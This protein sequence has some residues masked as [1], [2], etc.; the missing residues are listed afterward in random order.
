MSKVIFN[1]SYEI[2]PSKR[3][4]FIE[5]MKEYKSLIAGDGIQSYGLYEEK[6]KPNHFQELF[7]FASEES[8]DNFDDADND[9]LN[10]LVSKLEGMKVNKTTKLRTLHEVSLD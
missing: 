6:G 3:K 2:D 9:R 7:V 1:V 10:I 5:S 4:E 8:Y